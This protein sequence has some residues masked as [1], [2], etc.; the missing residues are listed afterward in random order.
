MS[1]Q[2]QGLST[3][4]RNMYNLFDSQRKNK[5]EVKDAS[6]TYT[7]CTRLSRMTI[8]SQSN[9]INGRIRTAHFQSPAT[10]FKDKMMQALCEEEESHPNLT[11]FLGSDGI[12]MSKVEKPFFFFY[13][14]H[15]Q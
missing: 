1:N 5:E 13:Y 12:S 3:P 10:N 4:H 15:K 11:M 14:H 7:P 6:Y 8:D 9:G 2:Q